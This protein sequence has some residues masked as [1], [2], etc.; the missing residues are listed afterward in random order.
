MNFLPEVAVFLF[1]A[2]IAVPLSRKSGFGSVLGYL[3]AGVIIGPFGLTL[4]S[5]VPIILG[6]SQIGVVLLLFI[7]GLELQPSRLWVMRR[8]VF[9]MGSV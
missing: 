2:C 8:F 1:A 5:D 3:V 4:I 7:I 9:G 6:F